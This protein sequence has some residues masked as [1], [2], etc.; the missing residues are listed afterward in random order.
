MTFATPIPA[1]S[2]AFMACAGYGP[3]VVNATVHFSD[4]T[5]TVS[6][7][8]SIPDWA[9]F[10]SSS[11]LTVFVSAERV[12]LNPAFMPTQYDPGDTTTIFEVPLS[13]GLDTAHPV[14]S[15]DFTWTSTGQ[16]VALPPP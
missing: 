4:G 11:I 2:L 7:P 3:N 12:H 9:L 16:P 10:F 8:L 13:L 1:N 14:T 5:P 15:V 6:A